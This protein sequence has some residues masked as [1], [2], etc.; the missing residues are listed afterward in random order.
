MTL[1]SRL[2]AIREASKG[3]IPPETRAI[4]ERSVEGLRGSGIMQR[5]ARVGQAAPDF[6]LPNATGETIG[7]AELRTRGPVVLSFYRGRW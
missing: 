1:Q 2:D 7:L 5:V 6:A 4:M 3:R